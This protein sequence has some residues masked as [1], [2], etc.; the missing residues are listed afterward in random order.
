[1]P[2]EALEKSSHP[3]WEFLSVPTLFIIFWS[4]WRMNFVI[5]NLLWAASC[6]FSSDIHGVLGRPG[7]HRH[8][9]RHL[10]TEVDVAISNAHLEAI[11]QPLPKG[12]Q[13]QLDF[14]V[15]TR[16]VAE[17]CPSVDFS[18]V[19]RGIRNDDYSCSESKPCSNGACCAKSGYC[20]YG[21]ASVRSVIMRYT[22]T[23]EA[24]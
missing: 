17:T 3:T 16:A 8:I 21:P 11:C 23:W 15:K 13:S 19:S 20:G 6:L 2:H 5:L 1:M 12:I 10:S 14:A 9:S 22:S 4:F 24:C 7:H 18:L